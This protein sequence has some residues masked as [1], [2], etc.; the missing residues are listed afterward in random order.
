M[1]ELNGAHASLVFEARHVRL[2]F[3]RW[4]TEWPHDSRQQ[5]YPRM[6]VVK[7]VSI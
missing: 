1:G 7:A 4:Q 3:T 2:A 6:Q 5:A